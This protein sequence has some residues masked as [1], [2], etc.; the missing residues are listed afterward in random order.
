[1]AKYKAEDLDAN[2]HGFMT[3]AQ[4]EMMRHERNQELAGGYFLIIVLGLFSLFMVSAYFR[5]PEFASFFVG[6]LS[7]GGVLGTIVYQIRTGRKYARDI[8]EEKVAEVQGKARLGFTASKSP[9]GTLTVG[10]QTFKVSPSVLFSL[11]NGL[12]Y[13]VYFAPHSKTFI[14][15]DPIQDASASTYDIPEKTKRAQLG[16]DGELIYD[17]K[18][19]LN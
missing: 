3:P 1:M 18:A 4:I 10:G 2:R 11:H 19:R 17:E 16:D 8:L 9:I 13:R 15:A 6:V 7:I 5:K 14:G 12:N